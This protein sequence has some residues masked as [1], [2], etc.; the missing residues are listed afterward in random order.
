MIY[1]KLYFIRS[2]PKQ[3]SD[4]PLEIWPIPSSKRSVQIVYK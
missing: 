1:E 2:V 4:N 3:T